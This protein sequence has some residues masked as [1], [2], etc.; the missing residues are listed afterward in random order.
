MKISGGTFNGAS[1]FYECNPQNNPDAADDITM[2]IT[3]GTFNGTVYSEDETGFVVGGTYSSSTCMPYVAYG[4]IITY[5][6]SDAF[7]NTWNVMAKSGNTWFGAVYMAFKHYAGET[8]TIDVLKDCEDSSFQ[9]F[10]GSNITFNLNGHTITNDGYDTFYIGS[11]VESA[12]LVINATGGTINAGEKTVLGNW[13]AAPAKHGFNLT[14][15]GGT[16]IGETGFILYDAGTVVFDGVTINTTT[17]GGIWCGNVGP[18]Q[19]TIEDSNILS[20]DSV[21]VYI[22]SNAN[23]TI[24]NTTIE[25][26]KNDESAVEIKSGNVSIDASSVLKAVGFNGSSGDI[27]HNGT[28]NGNAVVFINNAYCASSGVENVNVTIAK[29]AT[30]QYTGSGVDNIVYIV[31]DNE[32]Y[33]ISLTWEDNSDKVAVFVN[34]AVPVTINGEQYKFTITFVNDDATELQVVKVAY[35]EMPAYTGETPTKAATPQYTYTFAGWDPALAAVTADAT[36]TAT[37]NQATATY[38]VTLP[39]EQVGYTLAAKAGSQSPVDY[40]GS[41]TF[42]FALDQGYSM[43]TPVIKVND[44]V[45]VL[46]GGEY[47]I[48]NI[49]ANQ[50]VTVE[51]VSINQYTVAYDITNAQTIVGGTAVYHEAFESVVITPNEHYVVPASVTVTMGGDAFTDFTYENGKVTIAAGLIEGDIVIT[52]ECA[53]QTYTVTFGVAGNGT[54]DVASVADVPYGSVFTVSEKTVTINGTTVTVTVGAATEKYTYTLEGWNVKNGDT[55]AGDTAVSAIVTEFTKP[56]TS[57]TAVEFISDSDDVTVTASVDDIKASDKDNVVIGKDS[58][59]DKWSVE[60][61]KSYFSDKSDSVSVTVTD[62]SNDLPSTITLDQKEKLEGM[63]VIALDMVIGD[64]TEHQFGSKV[65]VKLAYALK[66]GE[67]ADNLFVY[68]VNTDTGALDKYE[69]TYADGFVSFETDHF[70]Y[71][72]VGGDIDNKSSFTN[73]GLFLAALLVAAIVAPIIVALV[74]FRKH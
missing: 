29:G 25:T 52:G 40:D 73:D 56:A 65:T 39:A 22:G 23:A 53:L 58:A 21:G 43:S 34:K 61:P 1:A 64:K 15:N 18:N 27:N 54:V 6:G 72:A 26:Q 46:S 42:T 9:L 60:L 13:F 45:V 10:T 59:D 14:V 57:E 66:A 69:A 67:S 63:T 32:T 4:G 41:Y 17:G 12:T 16:F 8:A 36:Y 31:T 68:Y 74:Y 62:V 19:L 38:T 11:D 71:W 51:G 20:T 5:A 47:T 35:G 44:E 7:Q 55:V 48:A 2:S 49:A 24:T 50:V 37:Y 3:G 28:G 70:S 30:L 33:P